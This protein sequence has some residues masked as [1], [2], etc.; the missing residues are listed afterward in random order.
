MAAALVID[1]G[2]DTVKV[3]WVTGPCFSATYFTRVLLALCE[4]MAWRYICSLAST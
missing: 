2:W 1:T 4:Q 3:G